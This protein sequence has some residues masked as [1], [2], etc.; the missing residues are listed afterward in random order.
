MERGYNRELA[1]DVFKTGNITRRIV[2]GQK[3][4]DDAEASSKMRLGYMGHLTLIAEE[5][6]KFTER[7]A[8]EV[9]SDIVVD[10]VM[11]RSWVNYVEITL[12]ATRERDNAILGGVRPDQ[13]IG[14]RAGNNNA[15]TGTGS[16]ALADA[17]LNGNASLDALDFSNGNGALNAGF[18]IS[19]NS[20]LSGFGDSSDE[21]DEDLDEDLNEDNAGGG[22]V[23][24]GDH[25]SPPPLD[26][27]SLDELDL[28]DFEDFEL[29]HPDDG[30][31]PHDGPLFL[32]GT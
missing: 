4:S 16:T 1:I 28:E 17:G 6:V 26:S 20:L 8:P 31:I 12:A 2:D 29:M 25:F 11:D 32:R 23:E 5:V 30:S 27:L 7:H 10:K 15:V 9:L 24:V 21:E 13:S 18:G 14:G 3:R 22:G 19:G